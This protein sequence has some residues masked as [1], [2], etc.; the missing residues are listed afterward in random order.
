MLRR[1]PARA[2]TRLLGRHTPPAT[3]ARHDP[4]PGASAP[5]ERFLL[6]GA[7]LWLAIRAPIGPALGLQPLFSPGTFFRPLLGPLS[8]SSGVLALSGTLLTIAAV[9]LWRRSRRPPR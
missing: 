3:E 5:P 4:A 6:L 1:D 8:S 9:W 2:G 7:G